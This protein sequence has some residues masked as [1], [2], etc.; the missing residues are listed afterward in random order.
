[1]AQC[2]VRLIINLMEADEVNWSGRAFA[3]YG[4][5]LEALAKAAGRSICCQRM[6]IRDVDVPTVAHMRTILDAI[7]ASN[8][9]GKIVIAR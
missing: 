6:P 5:R 1:M 7:D 3:D 8:S 4:P 9:A 2:G